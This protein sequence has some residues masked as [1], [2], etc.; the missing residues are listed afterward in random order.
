VRIAVIG[1]TVFVGRGIVDAA[2]RAGMAVTVFHRGSAPLHRDDVAEVRGDRERPEDLERLAGAGPFD[3][4]VDTCGYVP[5]VVESSARAL[6]GACERYVFISTISVY[7]PETPP[8]SDED[9]APLHSPPPADV[10]EVT[11]ETYGPLKVACERAADGVFGHRTLHVRPG[12][13]VGPHDPTGRFPYWVER[14]AGTGPVLTPPLDQPLQ[15]VDA[16]DLGALT[17]RALEQELGGAVHVVGEDTTFGGMLDAAAEAAGPQADA[18][19]V[20]VDA[21]RLVDAGLRPG[22]DLPLWLGAGA[23]TGVMRLDPGRALAAGLQRRPLVE[24]AAD[25]LAWIREDPT[26]VRKGLEPDRERELLGRFA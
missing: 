17:V 3:A 7:R 12:F 1:G 20:P 25:T 4:V 15:L 23:Q 5:R 8:G 16:R 9:A 22:P 13:V 21:D 11:A 6:A 18:H 19:P 10:E 14:M 24:T 26:A 2:V